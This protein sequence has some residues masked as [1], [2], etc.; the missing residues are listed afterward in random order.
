MEPPSLVICALESAARVYPNRPV[1]FFMKGLSQNW[2][3]NYTAHQYFPTLSTFQNIHFY[4]L[5]MAELFKD[6]PLE[7]WYEKVY[8]SLEIYWTH[9]SSDA[10]RFAMMWKYGGV[11]L[12]ADVISIRPIPET[13]FV[14]AESQKLTSSSV[15][16]LSSHHRFS[17]QCM[18]NFVEHYK[19]DVWGHQGPGV[20]TRVVKKWCGITEFMSS[21]DMM[22]SNITYYHHKRFYPISFDS[23]KQFFQVWETLPDFNECY[24]VHLWNFMNK[25]GNVMVPGSNT[26]VEHLYKEYCPTTYTALLKENSV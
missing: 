16:G 15:F 21:E 24:A 19:G 20:F 9:V 3:L 8:P 22:C 12:D 26:L 25:N 2:L 11:Y 4:P 10:C 7:S 18:K 14:A 13:N 17:W 6:T 1:V 23:W 5:S